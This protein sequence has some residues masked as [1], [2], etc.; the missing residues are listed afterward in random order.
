MISAIHDFVDYGPS[1]IKPSST[2]KTKFPTNSEKISGQISDK[3]TVCGPWGG[4]G[5]RPHTNKVFFNFF[6]LD[7]AKVISSE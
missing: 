2:R 4:E 7:S 5:A 1:R 6:L 3:M